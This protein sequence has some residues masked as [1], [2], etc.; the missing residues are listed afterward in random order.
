MH[1]ENVK[2]NK[3]DMKTSNTSSDR[4]AQRDMHKNYFDRCQ[5]A[6]EN[7]FYMEAILMEY[8]AIEARLEVILGMLGLPCNQYLSDNE[9]RNVNISC[10]I[11]CLEEFV[12]T[13]KAFDKTKLNGR[14]F[15]KLKNWI[16]LRNGYVHGLYK[17]EITYKTRMKDTKQIALNGYALSRLLYDEAGRIRRQYKK[18]GFIDKTE[19]KCKSDRCKLFSVM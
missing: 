18:E 14:Y 12:K 6:I 2:K 19:M 13:S 17:N 8:A 7:G 16:G 15:I 5:A 10:R 11:N 1:S 4:I 9:R 3:D